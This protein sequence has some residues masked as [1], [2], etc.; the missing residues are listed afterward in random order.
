MRIGRFFVIFW[1]LLIKFFFVICNGGFVLC[2][3]DLG[4]FIKGVKVDLIVWNVKE[5]FVL[6]GWNDFVVVV[7]LYVSVGDILDV[8]VDGKFVKWDGKLV[9]D[10]YGEVRE[11][12]LVSVKRL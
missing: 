3:Y 6:L 10:G 1:K 5:F 11:R 7:M 2:C 8:M 12:F 4:V 9:V